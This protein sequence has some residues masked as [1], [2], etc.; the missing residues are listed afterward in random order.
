MSSGKIVYCQ[1][2]QISFVAILGT[3]LAMKAFKVAASTNAGHI[4]LIKSKKLRTLF[5]RPQS[6]KVFM[7]LVPIMHER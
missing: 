3:F 5:T 2:T 6:Y 1:F 4:W 7:H